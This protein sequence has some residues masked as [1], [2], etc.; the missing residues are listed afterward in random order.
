MKDC[1]VDIFDRNPHPYGLIRTGV[2]PDHQAM[3]KIKNDFREVFDQ[4]TDRCKFFGNVWVGEVNESSPDFD[5]S[6]RFK[7]GSVVS[8]EALRNRYSAV[9]L[10]YGASKD[11]MLGL[12]NETCSGI[13][14][15]RR[16]VNWYNGS[17]DNDVSSMN[18]ENTRDALVIG[19]G[20]IFCDI[21]RSMLKSPE[22]L[23][24]TDM[25]KSVVEE[26]AASK[27]TN[28]QSVARRGITHTAFTTK[29]IR[30]VAA[31]PGLELYMVKDEV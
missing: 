18:L 14:P 23:A 20:N 17:L 19:N 26:L 8:L 11:R 21:A 13:Y 4:N 10:A 27:L 7:D 1:R 3:K 31:I 22:I 30:E 16:V 25:P 5:I 6:S 2:A 15:S 9:V 24:K 29:E 28:V 12:E